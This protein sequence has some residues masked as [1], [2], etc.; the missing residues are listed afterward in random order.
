MRRDYIRQREELSR[1]MEVTNKQTNKCLEQLSKREFN[2][3]FDETRFLPFV[4]MY[5]KFQLNSATKR[6]VNVF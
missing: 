3:N 1:L 2:L 6:N 5:T 4:N